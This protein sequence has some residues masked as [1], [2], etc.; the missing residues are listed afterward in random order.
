M[1][2]KFKAHGPWQQL[3]EYGTTITASHDPFVTHPKCPDLRKFSLQDFKLTIFFPLNDHISKR[4]NVL[5]A[6]SVLIDK[7]SHIPIRL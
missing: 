4:L 2:Y 3:H 1:Y 5:E 6:I 7:P